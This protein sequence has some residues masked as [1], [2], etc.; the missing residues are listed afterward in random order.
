MAQPGNG[1]HFNIK[2]DVSMSMNVTQNYSQFYKGSEPLKSYGSGGEGLTPKDTL[3]RYEFNTTDEQGNKIMEPM[4]KEEALQAMKE[5]SSQYGDNVL[6]QF[7]GDGLQALSQSLQSQIKKGTIELT[8]EQKAEQAR[9]QE[10]MEQS[11]VHLENTHRRIIPNIQTN[12]KLYGSLENASEETVKAANGII[13]RYLLPHDVSGMTEEQRRDAIAFGMEEARYLAEN[14]L[15][16]Q[17]AGDFL[18]AMETIAKYGMNGTV[19]EDGKVTYHIEQGPLV[20]APDDYVSQSD[21]L[22]AKAPDLYK[23]LQE[24]NQGIVKGETGWGRKFIEL[25]KRINQRL[26]GYSGTTV[27]GKRLT[28]YEEAA[29]EYQTW[30]KSIDST[31]VPN[32]YSGVK[33]SDITAFFDSLKS[34]GSLGESWFE[35]AR[36]RFA[37]WLG[38]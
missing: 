18:S 3:V 15:D 16:E 11:I 21:I 32:T 34:Q 17:H 2:E 22:K 33:R 14:Y 31:V 24:L 29:Y 26:N 1:F 12:E 4:S 37:K 23:E 35:Q 19:S 5:I 36:E 8:E 13:N 20:G 27:Q 38:M 30:K 9:K 6:V 10:L 28:Y 7:S 25:H